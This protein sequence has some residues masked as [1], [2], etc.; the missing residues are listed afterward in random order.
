MIFVVYMGG[1]CGDVVSS[2]IDWQD[3]RFNV[4][5]RK[6]ELP[7]ERQRLKTFWEFG[8]DQEKDQYVESMQGR[9]L[10]LPSHDIEYHVRRGH[11]FVGITV[12]DPDVALWAAQRFKDSHRPVMWRR[13]CAHAGVAG[14]PEYAD[15]M[16]H[17]SR[18][19]ETRTDQIIQLEDI[20]SGHAIPVIERWVGHPLKE[21]IRTNAYK[22]WQDLIHGQFII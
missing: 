3:S 20:V 14:V 12:T 21:S 16:L 11:D 18:M 6:M 19:I 7:R 5:L 2:L 22:N 4:A 9:Y 15:L 8:S 1:C 10:S 17:Y 13:V